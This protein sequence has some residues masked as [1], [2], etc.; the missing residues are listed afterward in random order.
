VKEYGE[1]WIAS[2]K[3][4]GITSAGENESNLRIHFYEKHG[5]F[6][7][8]G[9]TKALLEDFVTSLDEAVRAGAMKW[10]TARNVWGTISVMFD[11]ASNGKDR[12]LRV[13]ATNPAHSQRFAWAIGEPRACPCSRRRGRAV[14]PGR[15]DRPSA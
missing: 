8:A 3:A 12:S 1:A 6:P 5:A 4:R 10:K 7:I 11:E 15:Y 2:R 13:L 14:G 9:I